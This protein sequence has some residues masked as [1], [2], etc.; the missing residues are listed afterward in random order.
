MTKITLSKVEQLFVE[1]WIDSYKTPPGVHARN[2]HVGF[3][4][5]LMEK[6]QQQESGGG[7]GG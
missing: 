6:F 3:G 1:W 2:T 7:K 4:V 5:W